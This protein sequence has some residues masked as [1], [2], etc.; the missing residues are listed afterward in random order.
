MKKLVMLFVW[1]L[2]LYSHGAIKPF[3]KKEIPIESSRSLRQQVDSYSELLQKEVS[4]A[5]KNKEKFKTLHR[6]LQEIRSLRDN[7][8]SQEALDEAHIDL[9]VSVLESLPEEKKFKKK[10]CLKYENDLISQFEPM[11]EEAPEEP[12]VKPGWTVLRSLCQ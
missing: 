7:N 11:A 3:G 2:A 6:V 9:L 4:S 5:K 10:D 1:L 8:A 12:A